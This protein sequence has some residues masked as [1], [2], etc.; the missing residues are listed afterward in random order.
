MDLKI[1]GKT[2]LVTGSTAGI[3]LAIASLLAQEGVRVVVNGRTTARVDA[4][5][6]Q[7]RKQTPK[8]NLVGMAA[9][10]GEANQANLL[11]GSCGYCTRALRSMQRLASQTTR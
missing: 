7:I 10:V 5:M 4:A 9:D 8:A 1:R 2:A 3:G 11:S 6:E